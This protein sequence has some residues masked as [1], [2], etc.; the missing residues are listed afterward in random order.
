MARTGAVRAPRVRPFRRTSWAPPPP[1][2]ATAYPSKTGP[3]DHME[4]LGRRIPRRQR[5]PRPRLVPCISIPRLR[6]V[7]HP[8]VPLLG[9]SGTSEKGARAWPAF[10][11]ALITAR[12]KVTTGPALPEITVTR[13]STGVRGGPI[14][15]ALSARRTAKRRPASDS[16]TKASLAASATH[17]CRTFTALMR[18]TSARYSALVSSFTS[19]LNGRDSN[20]QFLLERF[21]L[22][23]R[24]RRR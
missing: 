22:G 6:T 24:A 13:P 17:S 7:P 4:P 16:A 15:L 23:R 8:L 14:L 20:G 11:P 18:D 9:P 19:N 2:S 3:E 1:V 21:H 12:P 5:A 10:G